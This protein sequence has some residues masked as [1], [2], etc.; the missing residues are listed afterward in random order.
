MRTIPGL[1]NALTISIA[2]CFHGM[3]GPP[4]SL[5]TYR[6]RVLP[7][8]ASIT[9]T[10]AAHLRNRFADLDDR[11]SFIVE[12]G[13]RLNKEVALCESQFYTELEQTSA[14]SPDAIEGL[15]SEVHLTLH[16]RA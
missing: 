5:M 9:E 10:L 2:K 15:C 4:P 8:D 13:G 3:I 16:Q 11:L 14:R 12:D 1:K 7:T 6:S